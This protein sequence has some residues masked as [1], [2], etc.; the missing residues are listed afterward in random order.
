MSKASSAKHS[1]SGIFAMLLFGFFAIILMVSLLLF[2]QMYMQSVKTTE[3]ESA[4]N[5]VSS[6][7]TTK[8]RQHDSDCIF[9]DSID[10]I[11]SLCFTDEINGNEYITYIYLKNNELKELFTSVD[12]NA[13]SES[14]T[15][16]ASLSTFDVNKMDDN[17][18]KFTLADSDNNSDT[19]YLHTTVNS[20]ENS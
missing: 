3:A 19:F 13:D 11:S 5:T 1:V 20:E 14:G 7:I 6:Y 15:T 18:Y 9:I 16:I 2:A 17:Y 8:F 12:S 4:F 10:D